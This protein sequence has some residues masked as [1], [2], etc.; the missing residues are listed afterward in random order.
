METKQL[1]TEWK[2]DQNRNK[3]IKDFLEFNENE[4]TAYPNLLDTKKA[5]LR[6]RFMELCAYI[7]KKKKK[8]KISTLCLGFYCKTKLVTAPYSSI[9]FRPLYK[10]IQLMSF[11][12]S[13]I[14]HSSC[15]VLEEATS[16]L[17][18]ALTPKITI[19]KLY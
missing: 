13:A 17:P 1:S 6:G 12:E 11:Y 14:S 9:S 19:Q 8:K 4:Y 3:E 7:K 2:T 15:G 16:V 18:V 5:V 10:M